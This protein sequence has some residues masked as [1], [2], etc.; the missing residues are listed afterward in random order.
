MTI[1]KNKND[2]KQSAKNKRP[3]PKVL[4]FAL[5]IILA[6]LVLAIFALIMLLQNVHIEKP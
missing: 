6:L 5:V 2:K 4:K 1:T 3:I